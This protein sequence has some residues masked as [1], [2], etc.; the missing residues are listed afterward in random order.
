MLYIPGDLILWFLDKDYEKQ[1]SDGFY[2][3]I[4][5]YMSYDRSPLYLGT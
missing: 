5:W 1:P 4:F 3:R 2:S